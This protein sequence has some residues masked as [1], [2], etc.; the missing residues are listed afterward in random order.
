MAE[1]KT[2]RIYGRLNEEV[3][4]KAIEEGKNKVE[5]GRLAGLKAKHDTTI[6]GTIDKKITNNADLKRNILERYEKLEAKMMEAI[7]AKDLTTPAVNQ[8]VVGMAI[9]RD[10]IQLLKGDPTSRL[11]IMP[12]MVFK[13][14]EVSFEPKPLDK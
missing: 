12:K 3:F 11:E 8:L 7:E 5:A 4:L 1:I 2:K 14:D 10:K 9:I 6:L 13:G